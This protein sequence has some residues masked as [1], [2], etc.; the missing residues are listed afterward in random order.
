MLSAFR[1]DIRSVDIL[2]IL[3]SE[4]DVIVTDAIQG[5]HSAVNAQPLCGV[6]VSALNS[7]E[8]EKA[9]KLSKRYLG[10]HR[11]EATVITKSIFMTN[12]GQ[13]NY[14]VTDD[15]YARRLIEKIGHTESVDDIFGFH[16]EPIMLTGTIGLI[17][18]LCEKTYLTPEQ[19]N[20]IADELENS[21]FRIDK[22]ILNKLRG[23]I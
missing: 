9:T 17:L 1:K 13:P 20:I 18:H 10:L 7:E 4:Y 8:A 12:S 23:Q 21:T 14:V 3:T 5:E 11:G 2:R 16:V 22:K 15:G 19:R 6:V